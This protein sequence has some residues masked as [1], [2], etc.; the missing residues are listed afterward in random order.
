MNPGAV[1]PLVSIDAFGRAPA[2]AKRR[3]D[4]TVSPS[5]VLSIEDL[6]SE[7]GATSRARSGSPMG[8]AS[9]ELTSSG[10]RQESLSDWFARSHVPERSRVDV[11]ASSGS[12]GVCPPVV[13]TAT[14]DS[15]E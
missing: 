9:F 13:D 3:I 15:A 14:G 8:S 4:R 10:R 1:P 6:L 11:A 2:P 12:F 5:W 7:L